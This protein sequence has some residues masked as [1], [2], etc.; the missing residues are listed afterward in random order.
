M[1][2]KRQDLGERLHS[3]LLQ[4]H[5]MKTRDF[6]H[7]A[8]DRVM[9]A[10][11]AN[12]GPWQP[13]VAE[14]LW[15]GPPLA[16]TLPGRYC[17]IS[18]TFIERTASDAPVAFALAH[19]IGHHDLG[20]LERAES[21]AA[22]AAEYAPLKLAALALSQLSHWIYSREKELAADAYALE[23]CSKSGFELRKCLECFDILSRFML[24]HH[25]VDGVY[26]TDEEL[27]L[28]PK[29]AANPID[30]LYVEGRL[31]IARHRRWHPSIHER[32]QALLAR[33]ASKGDQPLKEASGGAAPLGKGDSPNS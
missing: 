33:I 25:D 8:V 6:A 27:E 7:G 28:D 4:A 30:R 24:D 29:F 23:L 9:T 32:R 1:P 31:W 20:H 18:R 22:N 15:L 3:L 19:E 21:W 26:G 12:R 10:L 13:M 14:V 17:Y 11:N 16:F 2:R 5:G